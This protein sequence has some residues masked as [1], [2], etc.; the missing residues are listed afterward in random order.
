M[1][2]NVFPEKALSVG[3]RICAFNWFQDGRYDMRK[4]IRMCIKWLK[5]YFDCL[6]DTE[7]VSKIEETARFIVTLNIK[8]NL[9]CIKS[10]VRPAQ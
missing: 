10:L 7:E 3:H 2:Q 5:L 8:I 9:N 1:L 4:K 6:K